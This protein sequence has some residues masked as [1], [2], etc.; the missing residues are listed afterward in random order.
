MTRIIDQDIKSLRTRS[1]YLAVTQQDIDE[2][3]EILATL[4]R[5][6]LPNLREKREAQM[7]DTKWIKI[8]NYQQLI[9]L[10][11]KRPQIDGVVTLNGGGRS[12]KTFF[13]NEID[14][15]VVYEMFNYIDGSDEVLCE[16][17]V[18]LYIT[19]GSLFVEDN[20]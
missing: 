3:V 13:K 15:E 18:R 16:E 20:L 7:T 19:T 17:R 1:V 2:V 6:P 8:T 4:K 9:D 10:L 14:G 12:S 5:K 11:D